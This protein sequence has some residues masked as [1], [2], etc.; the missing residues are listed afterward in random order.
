MVAS[1]RA[2]ACV[3]LAAACCILKSLQLVFPSL[4]QHFCIHSNALKWALVGSY[5]Q[6][7][8]FSLTDNEFLCLEDQFSNET[9]T[10]LEFCDGTI[11]CTNGSDEPTH[12]QSGKRKKCITFAVVICI[13]IIR[14]SSAR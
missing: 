5:H 12:C 13:L 9:K 11:D 7:C 2:Y 6:E 8:P 14:V 10:E 3:Q 1:W 4:S